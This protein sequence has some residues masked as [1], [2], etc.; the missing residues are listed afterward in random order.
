LP[1]ADYRKLAVY[2]DNDEFFLVDDLFNVA[3]LT[4]HPFTPTFCGSQDGDDDASEMLAKLAL[5]LLAAR[6][7][8][9]SDE[10]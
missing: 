9:Y 5:K 1:P 7:L 6:R 8:K 10:E 4:N 3:V 2:A